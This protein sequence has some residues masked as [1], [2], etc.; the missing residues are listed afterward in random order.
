MT[1]KRIAAVLNPA[2]VAVVGASTAPGTLGNIVCRSLQD[3]GFKGPTYFV[4]PRHETIGGTRCYPSVLDLP[5]AVDLA[6]LLTPA[7]VTPQVL[8]QCGERGIRGAIL[9]AA[10]FR[11]GGEEGA[12]LERE[13]IA[14][15]RRFGIRF[16]GPNSLGLVR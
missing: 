3:A 5:Q 10:G 11:E 14:T 8:Q 1:A 15:A 4:N 7:A 2:S 6:V 13:S 16:L 12:Q 9:A